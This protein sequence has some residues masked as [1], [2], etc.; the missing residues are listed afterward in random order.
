MV[1]IIEMSS[2]RSEPE[3]QEGRPEKLYIEFADMQERSRAMEII[4]E[5]RTK[6]PGIFVDE[7]SYKVDK[8]RPEQGLELS[9]SSTL[10][11]RAEKILDKLHSMGTKL[12]SING[13]E[14][15][16]HRTAA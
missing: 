9:F 10:A 6:Y 12:N 14:E 8:N 11:G 3:I 1:K 4:N 7:Q 13:A 5:L 16:I 2:A 15:Q